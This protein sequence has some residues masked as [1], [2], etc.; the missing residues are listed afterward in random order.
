MHKK[1]EE[2]IPSGTYVPTT[3][4]NRGLWGKNWREFQKRAFEYSRIDEFDYF[5]KFDIANFFDT[6]NLHIL[7]DKIRL[8]TPL[9]RCAVVDL[10]FSFLGSWNRKV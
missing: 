4:Y 7:E 3:S 2:E 5:L 10:L 8:A 1:E 6:I 9:N